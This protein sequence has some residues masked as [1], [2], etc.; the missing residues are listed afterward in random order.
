MNHIDLFD[1]VSWPDA[2]VGG[3]LCLDFCNTV[4]SPGTA[5]FVERL[6]S[7]TA[8]LEWCVATSSMI[9]ATA[10]KLAALAK[11]QAAEARRVAAD[12]VRMREELYRLFSAI[13]A[14]SVSSVPVTS[15]NSRLDSLPALPS[16][17][18]TRTGN[19]LFSLPGRSLSEPLWPVLWSSVALLTSDDI[20]RLGHCHAPPCRYLF[21][22]LSR[23]R[24][25]QWCSS[26]ICGNRQRV[27]RAY[28]A[29]RFRSGAKA[30]HL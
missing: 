1:S 15:L 7:Y 26:A 13:E 30:P 20:H 3:A 17:H 28:R 19:Y 27:R 5:E 9:V 21:V 6:S 18:A 29:A 4:Q 8:L 24:T 14:R 25:R 23:N 10:Q 22:D 12:A 11:R 16:L 2:F